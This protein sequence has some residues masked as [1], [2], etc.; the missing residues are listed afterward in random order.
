MLNGRK[1]TASVLATLCITALSGSVLVAAPTFAEPDIDDVQSRVDSLYKKAEQASERY[2]DARLNLQRAQKRL[3]A[4]RADLDRQ[5][6]KFESV[7]QDMAASVVS[8]Y[9]GQALS[10]TTQVLLAKDPDAFLDQVATVSGY[11]D[12]QSEMM[13]DFAVQAQQL[14]MRE[15]AAKR[16]LDRIAATKKTLA[17]EK[18]EIDDK[19][20]EAKDLLDR[21]EARAAPVSRSAER[22]PDVP[23]SGRAG[24]AVSY[25]LGQVGDSYVYG[26]AGP[27]AFDCSGLTMMAWAQAGVGLPHSSGAQMGSGSPVSQDQLQPGDLVFYYSP[28]SHVGIYIGNGQI[29]HAANPSTGV[30][31]SPVFSMPYSGAVRPG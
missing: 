21:L 16:E 29:V 4:L 23:V 14:E 2:N 24:A 31:V 5:R 11:N 28:V 7:R 10:T 1:R 22:L 6:D 13:A 15:A 8:Q 26:A 25:A 30:Q 27:S 3:T 9:Q 17:D 19:A 18:A 12:Q 20:A